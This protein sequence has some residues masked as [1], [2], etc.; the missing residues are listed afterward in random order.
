[1]T[2]GSPRGLALDELTM[3]ARLAARRSDREV[4]TWRV[5]PTP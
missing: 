3:E 5:N 1:M 2:E 4:L